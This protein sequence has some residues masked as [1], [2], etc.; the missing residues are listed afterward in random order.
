MLEAFVFC[1]L[2]AANLGLGLRFSFRRGTS[3]PDSTA[4]EVFLGSRTLRSLPLALSVVASMVSSTGLIGFTAHLYAFGFHILWTLVPLVAVLPLATELVVPV[5]YTLRITSVF[6]YLRM[7]FNS[8]ISLTACVSYVALTQS[9]GAVVIFAASI[10][11][12]TVFSVPLTWCSLGI[13]LCGTL[14]TTLG[15]MRGVVWTDCMQ[16]L[17]ILLA[18]ATVIGKVIYDA[19]SG[20]ARLRPWDDLDFHAYALE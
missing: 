7:R 11:I 9:V 6:Q 15:G 2:M 1:L 14:Y 10:A 3:A 16:V 20:L 19:R 17:F 8:C 12:A 13:G 4:G 18:P 5:F